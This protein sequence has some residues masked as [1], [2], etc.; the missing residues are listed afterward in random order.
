MEEAREKIRAFF[1]DKTNTEAVAKAVQAEAV[2]AFIESLH[3]AL[4]AL[5]ANTL[6]MS[7]AEQAASDAKRRDISN[8]ISQALALKL[9]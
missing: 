9:A 4:R 3:E 1:S 5:P 2:K 8:L 7:R 6:Q